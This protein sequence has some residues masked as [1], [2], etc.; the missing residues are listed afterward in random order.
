MRISTSCSYL[1]MFHCT[2]QRWRTWKHASALPFCKDRGFA[3][4]CTELR[5]RL[6]ERKWA[7]LPQPPGHLLLELV[8]LLICWIQ[9]PVHEER[10]DFNVEFCFFSFRQKRSFAVVTHPMTFSKWQVPNFG[11]RPLFAK[12]CKSIIIF[13]E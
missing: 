2:S 10:A 6:C 1:N 7:S 5:T 9:K 8:L 11:L 13:L 12:R 3:L 4:G